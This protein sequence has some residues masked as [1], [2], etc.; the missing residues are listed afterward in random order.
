MSL[1]PEL[2]HFIELF[3]RALMSQTHYVQDHPEALKHM[4]AFQE[5]LADLLWRESPLLLTRG[6]EGL[7]Y[8]GETLEGSPHAAQ[9]LALSME[10]RGIGGL[11]FHKG[12]ELDDLQLLFFALLMPPQRV[13]EMGGAAS[14]LA[15]GGRIQ[16]LPSGP[17]E[18]SLDWASEIEDDFEVGPVEVSEDTRS[19][20]SGP[21]TP[22]LLAA[23]FTTLFS[24]ILQTTAFHPGGGTRSPWSREQRESLIQAGFLQPDFSVLAGAGEQLGLGELDAQT[25]RASLRLALASLD[26]IY[27]GSIV[28]GLTSFPGSEQALMSALDYLAPELLAQA[29][30]DV[31]MRNRVSLFELALLI[32]GMFE[33]IKDRAVALEAIRGRMQLEGWGLEELDSLQEAILWECQGTDTKVRLTL[34]NKGL[35]DLATHQAMTFTRQLVRSK[36]LDPIR[37]LVMQL[38]SGFASPEVPRRRFAAQI[39]ADLAECMEDPGLP[40]ELGRR[41][42]KALHE[43]ISQDSDEEAVV[44]S[45]QGLEALM[46]HWMHVG[47]FEGIYQEMMALS[48]IILLQRDGPV[49]KSTAIRNLLSRLASP[50]NLACLTPSLHQKD[51]PRS[52]TQLQALFSLM[53]RPAASYLMACLEI[54]ES[55]E[56]RTQLL[57]ALKSI[58]R[59]A[60]PAL[61]EALGSAS[62]FQVRNALVL[63]G[64]VGDDAVFQDVALTLGH[65]DPRVRRAA[66]TA[67]SGLGPRD[68][69]AAAI[70]PCL[71]QWDLPS[72]LDALAVLGELRSAAAIPA[73]AEIIRQKSQQEDFTRVRLRAVEVLGLIGT[74]EAVD[75]LKELF[76]KKGLLGGRESTAVRLSAARSLSAV[77]TREAREAIALALDM[78]PHEDVRSILRQFLVN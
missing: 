8:G 16:V 13:M 28:L 42:Q 36:S 43:H 2:C 6:V 60:V 35:F 45:T 72:Q 1:H 70:S 24:S 27:Q 74:S 46:V 31:S 17:S 4:D 39:V 7:L 76:K 48:E 32:S 40:A 73:I 30:A 38:E 66:M 61:V 57:D 69:A 50:L 68:R 51:N 49:W 25:I 21:P 77:N 41:L 65:R 5:A 19:E 44:W 18:L 62:W 64:E 14:L 58:G 37:D 10:A 23:D 67:L 54:E 53:G 78:E 63:L 52:R 20:P 26:G 29:V 11:A 33:G 9:T 3:H 71:A 12:L 56:R 75:P 47:D 15:E 59:N 55:R 34:L 22:A